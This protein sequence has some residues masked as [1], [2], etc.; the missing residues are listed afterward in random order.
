MNTFVLIGAVV[1]LTLSFG[2]F[3]IELLGARSKSELSPGIA[4]LCTLVG[5]GI[6]PLVCGRVFGWW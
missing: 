6:T 3:L 1:L 2:A 4:R 5:T